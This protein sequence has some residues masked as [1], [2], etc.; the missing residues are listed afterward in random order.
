M[1]KGTGERKIR[2]SPETRKFQGFL[3]VR[4]LRFEL[5]AS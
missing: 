1:N 2:K 3:L 5:R 4:V